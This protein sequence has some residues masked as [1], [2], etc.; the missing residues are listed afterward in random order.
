[1]HHQ[2]NEEDITKTIYLKRGTAVF[3]VVGHNS[4]QKPV[5]VGVD[6]EDQSL[7]PPVVEG[8]AKRKAVI[9]PT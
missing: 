5:D 2:N 8:N 6:T 3:G 4:A 1:M 7:L 9:N